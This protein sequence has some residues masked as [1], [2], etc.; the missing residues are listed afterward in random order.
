M[1]QRE[2]E[3]GRGTQ[4]GG[5]E[6][7]QSV[8]RGERKGEKVTEEERELE[9][10]RETYTWRVHYSAGALTCSSK[11]TVQQKYSTRQ[12]QLVFPPH[13]LSSPLSRTAKQAVNQPTRLAAI[14]TI[15]D[16]CKFCKLWWI[17]EVFARTLQRDRLTSTETVCP[18]THF[19][20]NNNDDAT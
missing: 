2:R 3:R 5:R 15:K 6:E 19:K 17:N 16:D 13:T 20:K 18:R 9:M 1:K 12:G 8:T 10:M 7:S 11:G 14:H 4:R